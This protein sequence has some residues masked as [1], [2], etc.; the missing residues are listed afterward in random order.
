V[1]ANDDDKNPTIN[2][3]DL[4]NPDYPVATFNDIHYSGILSFSWCLSDPSLVVSS[5][6][7]NRTVVTNFKTGEQVLEFPTQGLNKNIKWSNNL[8]GKICTMDNDGNSSVLSFEPEGLFSNPGRS[9]ATPN[10]SAQT[11]EPYMPKWAE[12]RC[13][14]ASF[15]FGNK[16]VSFN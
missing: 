10:I 7:D 15:G 5:G 4:R 11:N 9:F 16:L 1:V 8:H 3:W 2:I 13:G 6:K 14:A 12:P